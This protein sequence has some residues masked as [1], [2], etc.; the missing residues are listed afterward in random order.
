MYQNR[1]FCFSLTI[2]EKYFGK[3]QG[4]TYKEIGSYLPKFGEQGNFS[5][6][7]R[8]KEFGVETNEDVDERIRQFK[9]ILETHKGKT[10]AL[11]SHGGTIRRMLEVFGIPT[12]VIEKMYIHNA[13]PV[14]LIKKGETYV[15][16]E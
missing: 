5:F 4:A 12:S 14:V 8:E 13:A 11:F 10:V 2:L 7:G 9:K 3:F 1:S 6:Q 15:L 16:K